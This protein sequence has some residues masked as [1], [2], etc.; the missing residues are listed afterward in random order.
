M[1]PIPEGV[2]DRATVH[3]AEKDGDAVG[4][5]TVLGITFSDIDFQS[6]HCTVGERC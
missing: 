5:K 2:F 3:Q 1:T 4:S 6:F